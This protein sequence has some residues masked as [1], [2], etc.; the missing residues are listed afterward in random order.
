[1]PVNHCGKPFVVNGERERSANTSPF[2]PL[3]SVERTPL[4]PS[5]CKPGGD[6]KTATHTYDFGALIVPHESVAAA[7][8]ALLNL[9]GVWEGR[10]SAHLL[11][12]LL[13]FFGVE[14]MA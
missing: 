13:F 1:M 5:I 9:W 10:F 8:W 12:L 2:G 7:F 4:R 6:D 11:F 14:G 3:F